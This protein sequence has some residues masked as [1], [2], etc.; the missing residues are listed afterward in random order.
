MDALDIAIVKRPFAF[1]QGGVQAQQAVGIIYSRRTE[2]RGD[3]LYSVRLAG[4]ED[5]REAP[6]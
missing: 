2:R 5:G 6:S 3:R 4:Q 1:E